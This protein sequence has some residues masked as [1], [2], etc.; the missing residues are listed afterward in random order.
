MEIGI[1]Y[2]STRQR[3]VI[4]LRVMMEVVILLMIT[5]GIGL[6]QTRHQLGSFMQLMLIMQSLIMYMVVCRIMVCGSALQQQEM[7]TN[8]II[9]LLIHGRTSAVETVC[10]CRWTQEIIKLF[11]AVRNMVSIVVEMLILPGGEQECWCMQEMI[12]VNNN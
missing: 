12:W 1:L 2:G 10:R 7:Q 11:T 6:K 8:G 9:H 5:A 4:G 3:I